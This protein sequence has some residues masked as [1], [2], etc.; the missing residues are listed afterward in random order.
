MK[1]TGSEQGGKRLGL[2][3]GLWQQ[4][5]RVQGDRRTST[6]NSH[7]FRATAW[8]KEEGERREVNRP[9]N[10]PEAST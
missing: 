9:S 4:K 3:G 6:F 5:W 2:S 10:C 1:A 7:Q 8:Q